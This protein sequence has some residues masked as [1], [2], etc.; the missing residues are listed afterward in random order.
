MFT[1]LIEQTGRLIRRS[2]HQLVVRPERRLEESEIGESIAVNG[3]CL[4]LERQTASGEL[5]FHTLEESLRRTNLGVLEIGSAVNLER[6]MPCGRRFG[7]HLVQGH[8]DGTA[9]VRGLQQV[10]DG[11]WELTVELPSNLA[12][13][14]VLKGSIAIDGVSLTVSRLEP[15][16]FAVRLIPLTLNSTALKSRRAGD[17]V[18]LETDIIGKY[19]RRQLDLRSFDAP[20]ESP[21]SITMEKLRE[22][23]F[24]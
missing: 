17:P 19:V 7:G 22:A 24:C 14:L 15:T 21:S 8:I 11:D 18:N 16:F 4:S 2:N 1:G 9:R 5:E 3:C 23:G 6:A 12:P 13:E 20:A 10:A